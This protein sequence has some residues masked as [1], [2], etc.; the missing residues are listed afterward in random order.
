MSEA[1]CTVNRH[2]RDYD[3]SLERSSFSRSKDGRGFVWAQGKLINEGR[4]NGVSKM[5]D[6]QRF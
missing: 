5:R 2:R 4:L 1:R 3:V 6:S